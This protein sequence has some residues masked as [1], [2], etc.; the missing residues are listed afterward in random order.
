LFPLQ[1]H[2]STATASSAREENDP[3]DILLSLEKDSHKL[4]VGLKIPT[5]LGSC[6]RREQR[7]LP[8]DAW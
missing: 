2:D 4:L 7:V 8:L 5:F 6:R 3:Y 1:P